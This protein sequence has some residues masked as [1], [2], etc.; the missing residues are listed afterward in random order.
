MIILLE[1]RLPSMPPA[2]VP[3]WAWYFALGG[4]VW[5]ILSPRF[6]RFFFLYASIAMAGLFVGC[7]YFA[8]FVPLGA[9]ALGSLPL[10][11]WV[12]VAFSLALALM[13]RPGAR[14]PQRQGAEFAP[15]LVGLAAISAILVLTGTASVGVLALGLCLATLPGA[16]CLLIL[17]LRSRAQQSFQ[18]YAPQAFAF[19]VLACTGPLYASTAWGD[20]SL[21]LGG[22]VAAAALV[23][24]DRWKCSRANQVRRN[25]AGGGSFRR[26]VILTAIAALVAAAPT[27]TVIVRLLREA[28]QYGVY[29]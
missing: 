21:I 4:L 6:P 25:G 7:V 16:V 23:A 24:G 17:Q 28:E 13:P 20:V 10:S 9:G 14:F 29:Y 11:G 5:G 19:P 8:L 26:E 15:L 1:Q 3:S 27:V 2:D 22:C 12:A 18:F